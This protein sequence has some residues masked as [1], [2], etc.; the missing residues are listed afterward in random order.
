MKINS[1][2][3]AIRLLLTQTTLWT[4]ISVQ[5]FGLALL[6]TAI[7]WFAGHMGRGMAFRAFF[8]HSVS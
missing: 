3:L 7:E 6:S 8:K 4:R 2:L 5:G 1:S